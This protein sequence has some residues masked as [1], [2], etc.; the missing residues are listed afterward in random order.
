[1]KKLLKTLVLVLIICAVLAPVTASAYI[2][3]GTVHITG[4][5]SPITIA[6]GETA[7]VAVTLDPAESDQMPGCGMSDC[8]ETCGQNCLSKD[9]NCTCDDTSYK[10][11]YT[12]VQ[13][14]KLDESIATAEYA[15]GI[16]TITG[17]APGTTT[18]NIAARL[19][20]YTGSSIN[21]EVTVVEPVPEHAPVNMGIVGGIAAAVIVLL[22]AVVVLVI[23]RK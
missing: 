8:P 13:F 19:R 5:T 1:M 11:F 12:E 15:D 4:D 18:V 9:G 3:R 22:A 21:V 7:A 14:K 17:V 20:E 2:E 16:V 10:T 23:K 6:V